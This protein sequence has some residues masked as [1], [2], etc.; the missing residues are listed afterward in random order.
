MAATAAAALPA[1]ASPPPPLA[2]HLHNRL[3][4]QLKRVP[5]SLVT[6][7]LVQGYDWLRRQR[8]RGHHGC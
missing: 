3:D 6:H 4:G 1:A 8:T 7:Q 2:A 5:A